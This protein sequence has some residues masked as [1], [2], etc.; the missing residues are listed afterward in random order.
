M[1][2][3]LQGLSFLDNGRK[4]ILV[5]NFYSTALFTKTNQNSENYASSSKKQNGRHNQF[6]VMLGFVVFVGILRVFLNLALNC[7]D[8]M[9]T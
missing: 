4:L 7:K 6:P 9:G 1:E 2:N 3:V 5:R 8:S